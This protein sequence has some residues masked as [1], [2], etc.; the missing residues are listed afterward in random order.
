MSAA[1][2]YATLDSN[3]LIPMFEE[4][5]EPQL[6]GQWAMQLGRLVPSTMGTETYGSL[7]GAPELSEMTGDDKPEE[8]EA[9]YTY[10]L[11]NKEY[12]VSQRIR[13]LDM[14]RDKLGQLETRIGEMADK[15]ADHWNGLAATLL[16][17]GSSSG[18][19]SYDGATFYSATHNE[20]GTAQK[21]VVT[22][23]EI[24]D[25][26]I[27]TATAPT[28]DEAAKVIQGMIGW[29]YLYTDDKGTYANGNARSFLFVVGTA[30][31]WA[32]FSYAANATNLTSGASNP[33]A[34]MKSKGINIDV[35]LI[36]QLSSLT[37]TV[38]CFRTDARNKPLI[39]QE[40]VPL[41]PAVTTKA[42]D[43]YVKFRRYIFSLYTSRRAGFGNWRAATR[44][45]LS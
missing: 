4:L 8:G 36:P 16:I 2:T 44:G 13:E 19:T 15:A 18:Y 33:V 38:Q 14:R 10:L 23:S 41:E 42:S 22:A 35:L 21:N 26:N 27:G 34:G 5:Y 43:E 40:E 3:N 29:Q 32:P 24:P 1:G 7:G 9:Q 25:L 17:N 30:A 39:L 45:V 20:S 12:A 6:A 31:L 11:T 28:P 37:T